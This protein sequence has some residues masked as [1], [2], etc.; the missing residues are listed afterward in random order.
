[1]KLTHRTLSLRFTTH[2]GSVASTSTTLKPIKKNEKPSLGR[3]FS[4]LRSGR[5]CVRI[6]GLCTKYARQ[7]EVA[8]NTASTAAHAVAPFI[9]PFTPVAAASFGTIIPVFCRMERTTPC[10]IRDGLVRHRWHTP[11]QSGTPT[12]ARLISSSTT[13]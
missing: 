13:F 4:L 9:S 11:S 7:S 2:G 8:K 6:I 12:P 1:M 3:N 5:Y 10:R